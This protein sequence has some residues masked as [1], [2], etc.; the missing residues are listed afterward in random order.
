MIF[1]KDALPQYDGTRQKVASV[2]VEL[3]GAQPSASWKLKGRTG[4]STRQGIFGKALRDR[5]ATS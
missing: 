3:D 5:L 1:G 2:I 4:S